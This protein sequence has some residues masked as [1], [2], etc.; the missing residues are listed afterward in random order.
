MTL[1]FIVGGLSV[2]CFIC[3]YC[4][5]DYDMWSSRAMAYVGI[6]HLTMAAVLLY[7]ELFL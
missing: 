1:I 2:A 3:A 6:G 7:G 4:E 5:K